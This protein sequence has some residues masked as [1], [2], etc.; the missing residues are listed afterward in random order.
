[1]YWQLELVNALVLP[2]A[3]VFFSSTQGPLGVATILA[4]IPMVGLLIAGG[5]YWRAK[6]HEVEQR[7]SPA[8]T[9]AVL[10]RVQTPLLILTVVGVIAAGASVA[11][12]T[13]RASIYD[14]IIAS[15][16]A[17]LA[18]LEYINYYHVQLQHFDNWPDF[19][20]FMSGRGFRRSKL[21]EDMARLRG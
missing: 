3:A 1:M 7:R 16:A 11:F 20:R 12:P 9:V 10:A 4:L 2:A 8:R 15:A 18:V 17:S 14:A 6:L 5:L 19:R 21:R 13:A